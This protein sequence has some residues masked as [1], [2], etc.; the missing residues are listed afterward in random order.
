M[1]LASLPSR[2]ISLHVRGSHAAMAGDGRN[3]IVAA[4]GAG[5]RRN[6]AGRERATLPEGE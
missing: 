1:I 6:L 2:L 4:M 5:G 3:E